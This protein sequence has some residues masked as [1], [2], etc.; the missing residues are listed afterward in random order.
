[1]SPFQFARTVQRYGWLI[2]AGAISLML[3]P[4]ADGQSPLRFGGPGFISPSQIS[5]DEVSHES[6]D[7]LLGRYV[8]ANGMV[9]YSQWQQYNSDVRKLES[10]LQSLTQVDPAL[11]ARH[12]AKM[13]YYINAYN[14]MTIWGILQEYPVASIQ[15]IDGK[16]TSFAIFDDLKLWDG[17]SYLSLNGIENDV[18]RPMKDPRIHFALVC[19]ARGCP[20]LRNRAYNAEKLHW[21]LDDNA[22][23]F[24]SSY[25]RF[26]VSRAMRT[27][28]MSPIL[29]WYRDDFGQTD[30][31]VVTTV[32]PYLPVRDQQWLTQHHDW[33]FKYLGYDWS[34]NAQCP[35]AGV[36][37][38]AIP[39][40]A[41]SIISPK[42]R[43]LKSMLFSGDKPATS[44]TA[45]DSPTSGL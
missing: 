29:D 7:F 24:F 18:L 31:E 40:R 39:Y 32:F 22:R 14:A 33:R 27:V 25:S 44:E 13:A 5:F 21:Q 3:S 20:R 12:E 36:R 30:H 35:T 43:P 9:C 38:S 15:R 41:Y 10:Y 45:C 1:M 34:L 42:L 26:H 11:P 8:D 6:F 16:R 4:Q 19:A 17:E 23:E 28:H 37:I 2:L